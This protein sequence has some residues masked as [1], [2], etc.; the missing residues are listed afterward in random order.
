M[1]TGNGNGNPYGQYSSGGAPNPAEADQN[2]NAETAQN[3]QG[4]TY[5]A[6]PRAQQVDNGQ[7]YSD[8][9]T[10]PQTG[11]DASS[12]EHV[13]YSAPQSQYSPS[14][15]PN[16]QQANYQGTPSSQHPTPGYAYGQQPNAY[17][18]Y[19][20]PGANKP[21]GLAIAS[22]VLSIIGFLLSSIIIGGIFALVGLI[23]GIVALLR[24]KTGGGGKGLAIAGIV[25]GAISLLISIC[26]ALFFGW[27]FA[28]T[29][30]CWQ[31]ADNQVVMEQC[32]NE[33]FGV[34]ESYES[35]YNS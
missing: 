14:P 15:T 8:N 17:Q 35:D 24:T 6:A 5:S 4:N 20:V 13:G 19:G 3:N 33:K 21:K 7:P 32:M 10:A 16:Y 18:P 12:Q 31:Y 26:I 1:T 30:D 23:L 9:Y 25:V 2:L 29:A 11:G 28:E 34:S 27:F 22:L